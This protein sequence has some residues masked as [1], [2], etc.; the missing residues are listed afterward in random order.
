MRIRQARV[1]PRTWEAFRARFERLRMTALGRKPD[2]FRKHEDPLPV[3]RY[4]RAAIHLAA[5][6][7][8]LILE[9]VAGLSQPRDPLRRVR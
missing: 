2:L 8:G 6:V 5:R 3:R 4:Q 1:S 9:Q 7:F